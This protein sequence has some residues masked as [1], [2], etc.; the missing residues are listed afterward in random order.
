MTLETKREIAVQIATLGETGIFVCCQSPRN[1]LLLP[2][3][4]TVTSYSHESESSKETGLH[5]LRPERCILQP[6]TGRGER[7]MFTFKQTDQE[8]VTAGN[9]LDPGYSKTLNADFLPFCRRFPGGIDYKGTTEE[10][11]QELQTWGY[12]ISA[13]KAQLCT[14]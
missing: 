8:G 12:R 14:S 2:V 6:P 9:I 13:K 3:K 4:K 11:L 5:S 7:T 1:V 10:L